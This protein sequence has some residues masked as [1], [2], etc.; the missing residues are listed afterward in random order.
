[1]SDYKDAADTLLRFKFDKTVIIERNGM[2]Y[3]RAITVDDGRKFLIPVMM[4]CEY[5]KNE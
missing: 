2:Y 1:M 4:E 3:I 5:T